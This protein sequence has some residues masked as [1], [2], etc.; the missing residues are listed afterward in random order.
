VTALAEARAIALGLPEASEE[1]HHGTVSFRVRGRIFV[2]VE[3]ALAPVELVEDLLTE[4]WFRK[5]PSELS[6]RTREP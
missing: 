3:L 4:A 5:A 2:V 1:D 6:R